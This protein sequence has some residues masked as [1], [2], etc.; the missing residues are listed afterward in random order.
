MA[1]LT[2]ADIKQAASR[3]ADAA[4]AAADALN[5]ADALL[6]DGDLG[7]TVSR[8][9]PTTSASHFWLWRKPSRRRLRRR[10]AR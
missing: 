8:S 2:S 9:C 5:S 6:G 1:G 3:L 7:I 10:S 4:E